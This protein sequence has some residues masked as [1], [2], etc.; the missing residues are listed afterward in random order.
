MAEEDYS[1]INLKDIPLDAQGNTLVDLFVFLPTSKRYIRF[2]AKGEAVESERTDLLAN[3]TVN[4]LFV[5]GSSLQ[6]AKLTTETNQTLVIK[7]D[8]EPSNSA[9]SLVVGSESGLIPELL[10]PLQEL[11]AELKSETIG[12]LAQIE[13][14]KTYKNLMD[15]SVT[16]SEKILSELELKADQILT[17]VA[18]DIKDLKKHLIGILKH[19]GLMSDSAATTALAILI[20]LAQGYDSKKS[21]RDLTLACLI[22]DCSLSEFTEEHIRQ[23]YVDAEKL[24]PEVLQKIRKHPIK[25]YELAQ[26]K[27][28][29]ISDGTMQLILNH[30]ELFNGKGYP[31]GV[32]SESLFPMVKVLAL[33]VDI[34]ELIKRTMILGEQL[35]LTHIFAQLRQ[36][37]AEPH[38]R[39]HN[40]KLIDSLFKYLEINPNVFEELESIGTSVNKLKNP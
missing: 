19:I 4:D 12:K 1:K 8:K 31:R 38:L 5:S 10:S 29:S 11:P 33:A 34:F 40:R 15:P 32:R 3:H 20:S 14:Q 36:A 39:R 28:K 9:P 27:L 22:M 13:L 30:H 6:I 7:G 23:F 17:I 35:N 2:I 37:N 16:D 25:S 18:P 21:F 24:P 26:S